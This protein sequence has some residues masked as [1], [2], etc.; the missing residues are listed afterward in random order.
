MF[1]LITYKDNEKK[2]KIKVFF[3]T[4]NG[5]VVSVLVGNQS[6]PVTQGFQFYVDYNVANQIDKVELY[7]EGLTPKLRLKDGETFDEVE[8][9]EEEKEI[10][11]LEERLKELKS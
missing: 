2:D 5:E 8:E 9:S 3:A 10:R 6:V 7:L 11:E 1:I 4:E